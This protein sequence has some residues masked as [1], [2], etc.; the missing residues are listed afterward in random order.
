MSF[1][2]KYG[3][4]FGFFAYLRTES[5]SA[6]RERS[7]RVIDELETVWAEFKL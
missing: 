4:K 6:T 1:W 3:G 2:A 5:K 7:K